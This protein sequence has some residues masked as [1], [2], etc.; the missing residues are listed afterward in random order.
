MR[1]WSVGP[2]S[3]DVVVVVTAVEVSTVVVVAADVSAVDVS[4]VTVV[5]ASAEVTDVNSAVPDVA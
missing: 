4:V 1:R 3:S 5:V 2:G